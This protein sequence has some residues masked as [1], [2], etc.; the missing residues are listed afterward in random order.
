MS[1]SSTILENAFVRLEPLNE[2]HREPLRCAG[3]DPDL[4]RYAFVNHN[5]ADFD[6]WMTYR[7]REVERT[8]EITFAVFDKTRGEYVGS[9]SFLVFVPWF[10]R[11][12]IGWTWYAKKAWA[13]AVNPACKLEMLSHGFDEAGLNRI[14]FKLDATNK[15]SWRAVERLGAKHEGVH[16]A[17]MVMPDGRIRDSA[18]FSVIRE[19]WP[20]VRA[21]LETRLADFS[22]KIEETA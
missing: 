17:H 5:G 21:G 1:L 11:V 13:S 8:D 7:L 4:W 14:E 18:F 15:R 9:S 19:E 2:D 20:S 16:R 22:N 6:A 10:K 3:D 12:E